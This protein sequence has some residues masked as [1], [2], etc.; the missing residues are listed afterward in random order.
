M[1]LAPAR[2]ALLSERRDVGPAGA[3]GGEAGA[4]GENVLVRGGVE[5]RLPAKATFSVES[6][7]VL[8]IRSPGG[9]GWGRPDAA[10]A[11]PD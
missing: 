11:D 10:A 7:D 9:G 6:G 4:P 5:E 3:R 8:S 1:I 2:V